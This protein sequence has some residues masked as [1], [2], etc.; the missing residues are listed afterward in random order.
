MNKA[1][2]IYKNNKKIWHIN[3]FNYPVKLEGDFESFF[4]RTMQCWGWA[5]WRIDGKI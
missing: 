2:D 3:G 5:T 4:I 1:L